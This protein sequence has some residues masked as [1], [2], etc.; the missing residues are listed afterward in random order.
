M[1]SLTPVSMKSTAYPTRGVSGLTPPQLLRTPHFSFFISALSEK[2]ELVWKAPILR[3]GGQPAGLALIPYVVGYSRAAGLR[4][5]FH[6]S[7]S[8]GDDNVE[9]AN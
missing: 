4:R 9:Q 2:E 1:S 5:T 3:M 6:L 8:N 7:S